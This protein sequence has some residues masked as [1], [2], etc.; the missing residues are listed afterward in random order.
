MFALGKLS[1]FEFEFMSA[2]SPYLVFVPARVAFFLYV[3]LRLISARFA[4]FETHIGKVRQFSYVQLTALNIYS[5]SSLTPVFLDVSGLGVLNFANCGK[6][7]Q[8]EFTL[9]ELP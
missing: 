7:H 2:C 3:Q 1:K 4:I 5:E 8:F 9:A 6:M